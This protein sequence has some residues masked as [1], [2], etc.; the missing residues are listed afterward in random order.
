MIPS[1]LSLLARDENAI[2]HSPRRKRHDAQ[3]EQ[4][5]GTLQR[6]KHS[7]VLFD[8]FRSPVSAPILAVSPVFHPP[9]PDL[10]RVG[11]HALAHRHREDPL[12]L[13]TKHDRHERDDDGGLE[14]G[15]GAPGGTPSML[16]E[17]R[18]AVTRIVA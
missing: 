16:L 4:H 11:H 7:F 18:T 5:H 12:L 2:A 10:L 6:E 8:M 14:A 15:E 1:A 13:C 3:H 17:E 9:L